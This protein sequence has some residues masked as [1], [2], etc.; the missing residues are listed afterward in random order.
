M[1]TQLADQLKVKLDE[2]EK[3]MVVQLAVTGSRTVV[4]NSTTVEFE[5]QGV[6][7]CRQFDII[8]L[9][10]YDIILGTPFLFQHKVGMAFNPLKLAIRSDKSLPMEGEQVAAIPSRATDVLEGELD[11][12]QTQLHQEAKDLCKTVDETDLP[13]LRAVNHMIPLIDENKVYPW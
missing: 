5:Y 2:L 9:E 7:K 8:N 3:P 11:K 6:S 12:I 13:P 10:S 4:N 1:S